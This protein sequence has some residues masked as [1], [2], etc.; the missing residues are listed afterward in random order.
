MRHDAPDELVAFQV[1]DDP[2]EEIAFNRAV[3]SSV[4]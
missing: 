2:V 3:Y 1:G 4:R